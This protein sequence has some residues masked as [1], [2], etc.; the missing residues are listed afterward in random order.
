MSPLRIHAL[1]IP[2]LLLSNIALAKPGEGNR[3][4]Y[5][6]GNDPYYVSRTFPKLITPQWVGEDGV[7]AVVIL[8]IDDMRDP[9]KYE[10]VLR[11]ILDRLKKIDGRA[12]VSIMTNNIKPDDALIAGWLKEGLSI[13]IH[14]IDHP[15]PLLAGNDFAKAKSTYDRC[16]DLMFQVPGNA[17]VAFR[18]PCCDSLNTPSPRFWREIFNKTTAGG[19]FL[20]I[21]SSVFNITT[22]N[23]PDLPRELVLE[24]DGRERFRKYVPFESFVNTIDDYPYPYVIDRLCW[25]FPC[26]TPS[27]WQA[28]SLHKPNNPKTVEDWKA[29][30]DA[31]VI[32]QGVMTM[33][34]HP[35]GWIKPEQMAELIDHAVSRHGK[36]VKFLNF[37]EAQERLDKN[38]VAGNPIRDEKGN[39]NGVRLLDVNNDGY[40]DVVIGVAGDR[41][42]FQTRVWDVKSAGWRTIDFP[43]PVDAVRF[44]VLDF[45]GRATAL[46]GRNQHE[47]TL[48]GAWWT[49]DGRR[50][51]DRG[52][53]DGKDARGI[54]ADQGRD[55]GLR[56]RDID[57]DGRCELIERGE[58]FVASEDGTRWTK[59]PFT[60][61]PGAALAGAGGRDNGLRFVDV[62]EDGFDDVLF[63]NGERYGLYLFTSMKDGW[64]REVMAGK[65]GEKPAAEEIPPIVRADGTDNGAWFHSRHLWVQNENTAGMPNLVDR[66]S[67]AQ[68]AATKA[69]ETV[70]RSPQASLKSIQVKPGFVVELVASEPLV[71][72]PVNFDFGPDGKLWVVEM[73][74]YPLGADGK[75]KPGGRVKYLTDTN[76]DG[77]YDKATLFLDG[78]PYPDGILAWRKGVL[79]AAAPDIF[80]AEDTDGDGRADKRELLYT[81]FNRGNPQHLVNGFARGLDNWIYGANGHSGGTVKSVKTGRVYEVGGRDFRIRPDDGSFDPQAGVSQF[82]RCRDDWGNWFGEDN[83]TPIW[84]YV[85][86]DRYTRRNPHV[87]PPQSRH[88]LA[89][90]QLPIFPVSRTVERFNDFGHVNRITSSNSA[91]VY[92]DE[93]FGPAL[94]NSWFVSEPVH[95]LIHH[96]VLEPDGVTFKSHRAPGEEKSEFLA[97]TD[98]WTR[99]TTIRTG[100]DGALYFADMYRQ[101]IEHPE[102][103]PM[104]W[105]RKF[106]LR[107]GSDKGRIYRVYPVGAKLRPIPRLDQMTTMQLVAALD[108]P[109]GWQRDLSQEL[110]VQRNDR[111][112]VKPLEELALRGRRALARLHAL[113]ALDGMQRLDPSLLLK[114]LSDEHP[115]VRRHAVRLCER[116]LVDNPQLGAAIAKL[117]DDPDPHVRM[118]LACTLGEWPDD[119]AAGE[120]LG[121][122]LLKDERDRY[123]SAAIFSS[124]NDHNLPAVV[125]VAMQPAGEKA[126]SPAAMEKL[127][128]L[129]SAT[130]NHQAMTVLLKAVS[131]RQQTGY[132][133]S[134]FDAVSQFL[135]ALGRNNESLESLASAGDAEL[136]AAVKGVKA[137]IDD[138]WNVASRE[139]APLD[140]RVAAVGLLARVGP[141]SDKDLDTLR[142]MLVPQTPEALQAAAVT[143][144]GRSGSQGAADA[145]L[146]GWKGYAPDL[147]SRVVEALLARAD[148]VS[149]ILDALERRTILPAELEAERRQRLLQ[150]LDPEVRHRAAKLLAEV[151]NPDRQKLLESLAPAASLG[152]DASR[153]KATFTKVCATCH[154]LNGEGNEVGPDLAALTDKSPDYLLMNVIDPNRAVEAKYTNYV[155]ETKGGETLTGILAGETG[156]SVTLLSADGKSH[157]IL[158][159]DVQ[160]LRSTGTSLMPEGL[161]TGLSH[162]DLADLIAYVRSSAPVQPRKTVAGNKPEVV[163]PGPDG[164]LRLLPSNAEIYGKTLTLEEKYGNL[165]F[166]SSED[167]RAVWVVEPARPGRYAVWVEWACDDSVANNRFFITTGSFRDLN[168]VPGTGGWDNYKKE[169]FAEVP[170]RLGRQRITIST[171]G[172]VAGALMDLKSIEL[173]PVSRE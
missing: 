118:Q 102:W 49:F 26:A 126:P 73:A 116:R 172:P 109:N 92:R 62:N 135:G 20:T 42:A 148:G 65:R 43:A 14:T 115:G 45:N 6:D 7:E 67:F 142:A 88:D 3:L 80:Y 4:T 76:G 86:D 137:I 37:K 94:A 150:H 36:K 89:A 108:S 96:E 83:S 119:R 151:V 5:L 53:F 106:D 66:R 30:L 61:P 72:D 155:V 44:G 60:L 51:F 156:N 146:R 103:I 70:A 33:V 145:L 105:Q 74:D 75:G 99:P 40:M 46:F 161:E 32:K 25:E 169:K 24:P 50:W 47:V 71:Q 17:P 21:D 77:T 112:A 160:S 101:V 117:V 157:V 1:V 93:L 34:F 113:C 114:A 81:G 2:F 91:H 39:D 78:L 22:P 131:G 147:R 130:G 158:R 59:R 100:P 27:D 28:Q 143:A 124:V 98:N 166:W 12:P 58:V 111:S 79:L 35:H 132:A 154:K 133:A 90:A 87:A 139:D 10:Q 68:L 52:G 138:A 167:D 107:A 11:P 128:T 9:N 23:D 57:G 136:A 123:L 8:A 85:L 104:E 170:L 110:L 56:L 31:T 122:L 63:S 55:T 144:L 97:S 173:I 38:L 149:A 82:G 54:V 95:N 121:R 127:L 69:T 159:S 141:R 152:G 15:C 64:S 125:R 18:M 171:E 165:G 163:R 19:K 48:L 16:V 29:L 162:Q 41:S 129:A 164:S 84:H 120:A 13:E 168:S 153:G 134:Q 140:Q